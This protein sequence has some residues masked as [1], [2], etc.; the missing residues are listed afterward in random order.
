MKRAISDVGLRRIAQAHE[1]VNPKHDVFLT[2]DAAMHDTLLTEKEY[3]KEEGRGLLYQEGS[4]DQ[5]V[6][7]IYS[8]ILEILSNRFEDL[9]ENFDEDTVVESVRHFFSQYIESGTLRED[10]QYLIPGAAK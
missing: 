2:D 4:P 9:D 10:I 6:S 7:D 3:E 1:D 5:A 8:E